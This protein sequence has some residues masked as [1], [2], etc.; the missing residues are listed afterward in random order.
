MHAT[1]MDNGRR[2]FECYAGDGAPATIVDI[3]AMDVNGS[4]RNIAPP[5]CR[6]VGVDTAA[7]PGVDLVLDDP[8]RLPFAAGSID[9]V[10]S[11]SCF[12][13][14]EFFWLLFEEVL[15]VLKPDGLFYLN[16]PS[17]GDVHRYP[18]DCW[19]FFPDAGLALENWGRRCGHDPALLESF[20]TRQREDIWNDFVAVFVK[21]ASQASRHPARMIDRIDDC[22]NGRRH[23]HP[24]VL[25]PQTPTEDRAKARASDGNLA[26]PGPALVEIA[27]RSPAREDCLFYHSYTLPEGEVEGDWDLRAQPQNYLGDVDFSGRSVLEVGPASGFLSFHMEAAGARVTCLEPPMSHLWDTVPH[28][29]FDTPGWRASFSRNIEG[30]RSSFWYVHRVLDS[31][32]RMIEADPCA[33]PDSLGDF[34]IGVFASVLLHCRHP[35]DML[36]S[37]AR[38]VRRTMVVTEEFNPALG[39]QAL[40]LLQPHLGVQQVDTWWQF[41]PQFFV[42]VL[43]LL[44]FSLPRVTFHTQRQ[45]STGRDVSMFTVVCERSE[46]MPSE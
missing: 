14:V 18:V 5:G 4:L 22:M 35:F 8:Y 24:D 3:G 41:T 30:V 10:V 1:A 20:T 17:N 40:C 28:S 16:A 36:E 31:R 43:G 38:R 6:Y 42:S 9:A 39:P 26:P 13:H 34:D 23:G 19:R 15:R 29:G 7:G 21:D 12:E 27:P 32:V 44:G 25:R 33:I 45:P 11:S 2:F 37:A 46:P